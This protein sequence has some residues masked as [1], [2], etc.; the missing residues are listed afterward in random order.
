MTWHP[1]LSHVNC[2]TIQRMEE[3][4]AVEGMKITSRELPANCKGCIYG[5]MS[6][7]SFQ[8]LTE[9]KTR[10][11]GKLIV[12]DI[13]GPM[14]EKSLGGALYYVAMKDKASGYRHVFCIKEKSEVVGKFKIYIPSFKNE[15]GRI[16]QCVRTDNGT[17]LTIREPGNEWAYQL[18]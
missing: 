10:E 12:S 5:K 8:C 14:Q 4:N 1:R 16:I 6:C 7:R 11:V 3:T 18:L 15:T 17:V 13:G 2:R 9:P